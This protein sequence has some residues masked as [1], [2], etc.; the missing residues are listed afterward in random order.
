M[1]RCYMMPGKFSHR[2][3]IRKFIKIKSIAKSSVDDVYGVVY[4]Y[5]VYKIHAQ[6]YI[7][8]YHT[9]TYCM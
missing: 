1:L 5:I 8:I 2:I 3:R 9:A 6:L 7:H 4:V